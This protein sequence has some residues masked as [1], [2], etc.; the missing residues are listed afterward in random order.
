MSFAVNESDTTCGPGRWSLS[1]LMV[2]FMQAQNGN[3]TCNVVV[4]LYS[5]DAVTGAPI[6]GIGIQQ[7]VGVQFPVSSSTYTK[8]A[9]S[10]LVLDTSSSFG[11]RYAL[12]LSASGA[13]RLAQRGDG[14]APA[15]SC[16]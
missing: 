5:V 8:L 10:S 3:A 15:Y 1:E 9:L 13:C 4:H 16:R 7:F 12:V 11:T 14:A 2:S 6:F